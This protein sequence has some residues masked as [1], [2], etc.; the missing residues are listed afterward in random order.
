MPFER[1]DGSRERSR[2]ASARRMHVLRKLKIPAFATIGSLVAFALWEQSFLTRNVGGLSSF[3]PDTNVGWQSYLPA[4][5]SRL[6]AAGSS[7]GSS[8]S[9][10]DNAVGSGTEQ[11]DNF[12]DDFDADFDDLDGTGTGAGG[13]Q[14]EAVSES[15]DPFVPNTAPLTEITAKSCMWPPTVYDTCMPDSSVREDAEKGKW[16]RVEKDMNLRV[17]VCAYLVIF[18]CG[19]PG[20]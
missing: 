12:W 6:G 18:G 15:W 20:C 2:N 13:F 5:S 14:A 9:D 1:F 16:I 8:S 17:G 7:S 19:A 11:P 4:Y 3:A 10:G